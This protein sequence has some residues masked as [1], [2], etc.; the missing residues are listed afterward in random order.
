MAEAEVESLWQRQRLAEAEVKKTHVSKACIMVSICHSGT[1]RW[2][3][4]QNQ[5]RTKEIKWTFFL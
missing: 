5:S 3:Q 4:T 2:F 1:I